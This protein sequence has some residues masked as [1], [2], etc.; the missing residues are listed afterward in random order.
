MSYF[1]NLPAHGNR[2]HL[3]AHDGERASELKQP[4]IPMLECGSRSND[5]FGVKGH[6]LGYTSRDS[7]PHDL[8]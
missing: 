1:E 2:L 3:G 5:G 6:T 8:R 7:I 4:E